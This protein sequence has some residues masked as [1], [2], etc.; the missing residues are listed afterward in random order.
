MTM[1]GRIALVTGAGRGIGRAIT[2]ELARQG[3]AMA[4]AARSAVEIEALAREVR[5][6][7]GRAVAV[8]A[9][10]G[11]PTHVGRL[12]TTVEADLGPVEVLVCNAGIAG[13]VAFFQNVT[14]E[15]W[16]EVFRV[17]TLGTFLC[18]RAV[19]PG[20]IQRGWGRIITLS[21]GGAWE[22]MRGAGPYSASK[23]AVEGLTRTVALEVGRYGV[24]CN[25]IQPG[26]VE[27]RNFPIPEDR[28]E[29]R[30]GTVGP[31]LAARCAAW[32]CTADAASV[33]GQTINAIQ[34]DRERRGSGAEP[35]V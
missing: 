21:G 31:E 35:G 17:N 22:G 19:L 10:V 33:N 28:P 13:P 2:L 9:D 29:Q 15:E 14:P 8:Q 20:M 34:W 24:T 23:S 16:Q 18:I 1:E 3:A 30:R 11:D 25:A 5:D 12:A 27:T 6:A 7:G 26:R 4:L 32:L